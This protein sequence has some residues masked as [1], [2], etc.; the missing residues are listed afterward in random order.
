MSCSKLYFIDIVGSEENKQRKKSV[1]P[2][3]T[4]ANRRLKNPVE[5]K[6]SYKTGTRLDERQRAVWHSAVF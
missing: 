6:L 5:E 4:K 1:V 2:V 3:Q